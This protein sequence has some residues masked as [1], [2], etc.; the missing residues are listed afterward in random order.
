ML[1]S[2]KCGYGLLSLSAC[3]STLCSHWWN[4]IEVR[5]RAGT[6][7]RPTV[8]LHQSLM[9]SGRTKM[10]CKCCSA[11][12]RL[13][14]LSATQL[15]SSPF[16]LSCSVPHQC[17]SVHPASYNYITPSIT[18]PLRPHIGFPAVRCALGGILVLGGPIP[19][20]CGGRHAPCALRPLQHNP[21][22]TDTPKP[23]TRRSQYRTCRS[24]RRCAAARLGIGPCTLAGAPP[25]RCH[26]RQ[27]AL[28]HGV[29]CTAPIER[30]ARALP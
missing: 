13:S 25:G 9:A 17:T 27:R 23:L 15:T 30:M 10:R 6:E 8:C 1:C 5:S 7:S 20:G 28:D 22:L 24:A 4:L 19:R 16:Q 29:L 21:L 14:M 26:S 11:S 12:C 18:H 3:S 2:S